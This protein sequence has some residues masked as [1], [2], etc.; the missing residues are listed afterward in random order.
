MFNDYAAA[1]DDDDPSETLN[2]NMKMQFVGFVFYLK[3]F[4][5]VCCSP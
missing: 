1:I 3:D 4:L 5:L 2:F